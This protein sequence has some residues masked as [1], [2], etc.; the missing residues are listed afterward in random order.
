MDQY[1]E[2]LISDSGLN[3]SEFALLCGVSLIGSFL[4][5]SLGLGG[6]SLTIATMA[7]LMPPTVLIPI[8]GVV[9]LGSNFGRAMLL[10]RHIILPI[11]PMFLL[12]SLVG[13]IIGGKVVITLP[14]YLLQSV[15]AIFILYSTWAPKFT[16][17][18]PKKRTFFLVGVVGAFITMFVGATGP[19][20][21]PFALAA[22][23]VRHQFVA[24]HA[25]FMTIH[26]TLK[27][28]V[29]GI[30]GF[31]FGPYIPLLVGLLIFGFAGTYLGKLMLNRLPEELFRIFLKSILTIMAVRL[32]YDAAQAYLN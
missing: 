14:T 3:F 24:T 20:V 10:F 16:A 17:E 31:A 25:T 8:H 1:L 12:G 6:G 15:L 5:A 28:V 30:L 21:A 22:S 19:V 23:K 13:I 4:T 29:F 26:H 18:N 11:L 2:F 7:L 9:Q 32:L 27:L